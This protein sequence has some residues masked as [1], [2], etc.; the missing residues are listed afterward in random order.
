[1]HVAIIG[2][3]G[4]IGKNLFKY[5]QDNYSF[6]IDCYDIAEKSFMLNYRCVDITKKEAV[7]LI[8]LDVDIIFVLFGL[9]G[10]LAGFDSYEK[11]ITINEI[12]LLNLLDAIKESSYRPRVVFPSTRL[13]YKGTDKALV[14]GDLKETKTIYAVNK[15]ACE[16]F[17]QA[18]YNSFEIPFTVF[19]IGVPYGTLLSTN[20]SYGTIGL[21]L[22]QVSSEGMITLYGDGSFKRT[23][24]YIKDLC[25]QIVEGS[26]RK[27]S[28]GGIYNVGGEVFTLRKIAEI[29]AAKYRVKVVCV[30]WPVRALKIESYHTYFDD[31]KIRCLLGNFSYMS[32]EKYVQSLLLREYDNKEC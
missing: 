18:Y 25:F 7:K 16:G 27:E 17:L 11:Y 9:T 32:I 30:P 28:V 21:F 5:L 6:D 15:L 23:F 2:A 31:T 22:K 14:E 3:N 29:I 8:D 20:Y 10:T 13:V 1:M 26:M 12:G 19:R 4:Y 24:T